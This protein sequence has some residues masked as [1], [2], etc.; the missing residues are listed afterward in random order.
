M[1]KLNYVPNLPEDVALHKKRHDEAVNGIKARS[2]KSDRT[3][4]NHNDYRINVLNQWSPK[5]QRNRAQKVAI[6]G[7]RDGGYDFPS[8]TAEEPFDEKDV[9]VFLLHYKSRAV[10]IL[11]FSYRSH[12][13]IYDWE[14]NNKLEQIS[15]HSPLWTVDF[16][17]VL[18]KHRRKN[19]AVTL[20]SEAAKYFDI[21]I[22]NVAWYPPISENGKEL[23]KSMFPKFMYVGQ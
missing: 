6:L 4:W 16:V 12:I 3:I 15:G 9:H 18:K 21:K 1:C 5:T 14:K 7:K 20:I 2:V 10:G 22:E 8:Y 11:V 17:W 19:L 23:S 13:S